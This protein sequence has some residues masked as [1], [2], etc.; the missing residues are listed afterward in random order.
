MDG[1]DDRNIRDE[2]KKAPGGPEASNKL[3]RLGLNQRPSDIQSESDEIGFYK[4][5]D[6]E[7]RD[8]DVRTVW[9]TVSSRF[10]TM[11]YAIWGLSLSS[12]C[13]CCA[14]HE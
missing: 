9:F 2:N 3:L 8:E 1:N 13:A 7:N 10:V 14:E 5:V 11:L 4:A 6:G 12:S